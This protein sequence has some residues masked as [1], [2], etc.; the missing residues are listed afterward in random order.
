MSRI[1][2]PSC[3]KVVM[4]LHRDPDTGLEI[5]VCPECQGLWFDPGELRKF[6]TSKA[7]RGQFFLDDYVQNLQTI[8]YTINTRARGC[9]RC[10]CA[11]EEKEVGGVQVDLCPRC[12][13]LWLDHGELKRLVKKQERGGLQGDGRVVE[14]LAQGIRDEKG[15][16]P[17]ATFFN[18]LKSLFGK[19]G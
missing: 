3:R 14:Q 12:D 11:L 4:K 19:P 10:R 8:G 7:L 6:F 2:C 17:M 15:P 5:D 1:G 16:S 18:G 9:P 13:G